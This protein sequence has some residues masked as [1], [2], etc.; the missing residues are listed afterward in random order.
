MRQIASSLFPALLFFVINAFA[1]NTLPTIN[2][3]DL[4]R[5][6]N[7]GGQNNNGAIVTIYGRGFGA[8]RGS[9]TVTIGGGNAASYLQWS[10]TRISFQLG[11]AAVTGNIV[12]NVAGVGSSNGVPFTLKNGQVF[13]VA[14]N[15]SDS[16][17]GDFAS[18]WRTILK[19]KNFSTPGDII[20]VMDGVSESGLDT[21][22][23][24]LALNK[25]GNPRAPIA[26]VAYPGATVTVGSASGQ[27]YGILANGVNNWVLAGL[28]IRGSLS[29]L[30]VQNG[31]RWRV[32]A[33]DFS[34]P[35]GF[36]A[37]SCLDA[38]AV[39]SFKFLGNR[40]HDS[41]SLTSTEINSYK[42]VGFS[43]SSSS[44]EVGWNEIANTNSCRALQF[45]SDGTGLYGLKVHDNVIHDAT[46]D[47]IDFGNVNPSAG[48]VAAYNNV[49]YHVGTGPAPGGIE[50]NYTCINVAGSNSGSVSVA[51]NTMYDCGARKN[52]DSGAISASASVTLTDNVVTVLAGET[53]LSAN[54]TP[55]FVSG[56][57]NLFSGA[58]A[59]PM[60]VT[61]SINSD[62]KFVDVA[63]RD[64]S[65]QAGSPAINAGVSTG[66]S[67]DI[68]GVP[69]PQGTA[70]DIGAFEYVGSTTA[71]SPIQMSVSPSTISF[72][73][74]T[75]GSSSSQTVT[76]S[77]SSSASV[78]VTQLNVSGVPFSVNG[79][80]LPATIAA[81]QSATFNVAFAP[82]TA[83]TFS[84]TVSVVSDASNSPASVSLSGTG[85]APA[86]GQ[87][88]ATPASVSFGNV[89][90]GSSSS[91]NVR[92]SN[93]GN[94]NVAISGI[95]TTGAGF[96]VAN[97][98]LPLSLAPGQGASVTVTFAPLATG[99]VS[100][101]LNVASNASNSPLLISL[102]A[103]G[104]A[105][106][107]SVDLAW[108][109]STSTVA[110]YYVYRG[111]QTSGPYTRLN[112]T[113]TTGLA[114][115]D[116]TVVSGQTYYYVVT[117]VTS[118]G[119][120]SA[121]STEVSSAIP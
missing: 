46:C 106:Q 32:V 109:A 108:S 6:P 44:V 8:T 29:A 12:V 9:S 53:Y 34:C 48:S 20:Y 28:T 13:F 92:L 18:P 107:H 26:L 11:P 102:S 16:S 117:A 116:A 40:V 67:L 113:P 94:A 77:N 41:G 14:A 86:Q 31:S 81:G 99:T 89:T 62:P 55:S 73:S 50:A 43:S 66:V 24:S 59:A 10:D 88:A 90:V 15:G 80:S 97:P 42:S 85:A 60:N 118:D 49:I 111:T 3:S 98:T 2:Y 87:L 25:S 33:S 95:T 115:T 76:L 7:T 57:N 30:T 47:G 119:V 54:T 82:Q 72:G 120:E 93:N 78:N 101:A 21:S 64:F 19:A 45:Y 17:S 69:R 52:S 114:F 103:S 23:A 71:P 104:I 112:S 79:M 74:V 110:G 65:L 91:V 4:Q 84:G 37:S 75:T 56:N 61:A 35:N 68:L 51:N 38:S 96:S 39:Q 58:G 1:Q 27:Q 121:Y 100:G 83:S 105:V 5:G 22:N 70:F 36:G 63:N